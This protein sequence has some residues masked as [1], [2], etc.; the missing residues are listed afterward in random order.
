MA[1]RIYVTT[2]IITGVNDI[3][4]INGLIPKNQRIAQGFLD[5]MKQDNWKNW[6]DRGLLQEEGAFKEK[7]TPFQQIE[8][9]SPNEGTIQGTTPEPRQVTS[10]SPV[11]P[12]VG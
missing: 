6:I 12:P 1:D 2:T 3:R 9:G 8:D 7:E 11:I 4:F 5:T 10:D